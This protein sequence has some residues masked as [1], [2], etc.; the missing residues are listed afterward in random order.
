MPSRSA[1]RSPTPVALLLA[2]LAAPAVAEEL[3]LPSDPLAGTVIEST[4]PSPIGSSAVGANAAPMGAESVMFS[5]APS[6]VNSSGAYYNPTLGSH[7]RARYNTQSYGQQAGTLELGT[8]KLAPFDNGMAFIDGQVQMNDESHVGYNIGVGYRWLTLPLFP[9]SPDDQK[10][11]GVSLWSDGT[12]VGGD[13]FF[14]QVGVSLEFL[15]DHLDFRANGYA[16]V[17]DRHQVRDLAA[18]GEL[19]FSGNGLAQQLI[20]V[21]DTALTVGELELAGRIADLD[22]WVFGGAYGFN[23][24]GYEGAGGKVGL[25]GYAT[26][27]LLLSVAIANDDEF[28]TN[29]LF[30]ATWF[31]GRTRAE[32]CPRGVLTD[33]FREPVV[34]NNYVATQQSVAVATAD[35][36]VDPDNELIRIVHVDSTAAAGGDGTFESPLNSLDEVFAN[37]QENDIVL[38]HGGSVFTGQGATLQDGQTF[39]GEGNNNSFSVNTFAFGTVDL[40]ETAAGAQA[41]AIPTINA[42][43]VAGVTLADNNTVQNLAFDGGVSAIVTD[44]TLG[45]HNMTLQDLTIANTTSDGIALAA[46]VAADLG[47]IDGDD[48]TTDTFNHLGAVAITDIEFSGVG[49]SD[50]S[51]DA[52]SGSPDTTVAES[53]AISNIESSGA[54]AQSI[55]IRNTSDLT[56]AS[57]SIT[58]FDY[59]GGTVGGGAL[60]I[61][62]TGSSTVVTQSTFSGGTGANPTIAVTANEGT[63]TIGSTNSITDVPGTAVSVNGNMAAVNIGAEISTDETATT[64]VSGGGVLVNAN[65]A[66]VSFTGAIDTHNFD[67]VTITDAQAGVTFG[68]EEITSTGT[69]DTI[70]INGA[71]TNTTDPAQITFNGDISN[72]ADGRVVNIDGGD[73]AIAFNGTVTEEGDGVLIQNRADDTGASIAFNEQVAITTTGANHGVQLSG[74]GETSAVAFSNVQIATENG[75]GILGDGGVLNIEDNATTPVNTITTANGRAIDLTGGSSA[76]GLT[77]AEVNVNA[78]GMGAGVDSAILLSDFQGDVTVNGGTLNTTG[79]AVG[80]LNAGVALTD[81]TIS[82]TGNQAV[83]ASINNDTNRSV[84]LTNVQANAG[85]LEFDTQ[86][87]STGALSVTVDNS[88]ATNS[89]TVGPVSFDTAG[90]GASSLTMDTVDLNGNTLDF[91]TADSSSLTLNLNSV[92]GDALSFLSNSSA[93]STVVINDSTVNGMAYTS[94]GDG[95]ID[96][97]ATD[98]SGTGNVTFST[99]GSGGSSATLTNVDMGTGNFAYTTAGSSTLAVNMDNVDGAAV[100]FGSGSSGNSTIDIDDSTFTANADFDVTG[101]GNLAATMDT[102]TA[103]GNTT[104][105]VT[106]SGDGSLTMTSVNTGGTLTAT[107][108]GGSTGDLT[109]NATDSGNTT[110]FTGVTVNQQGTGAASGSFTNVT[111]TSGIDFDSASDSSSTLVVNGG[112]YNNNDIEFDETGSGSAVVTVSNVTTDLGAITVNEGGAG[113]LDVNLTSVGTAANQAGAVT[114]TETGAGDASLIMSG[115]DFDGAIALDESGDGS[116]SATVNNVTSTGGLTV[117]EAGVGNSTVNADGST[118]GGD[119]VVSEL[120]AGTAN[121]SLTNVTTTGGVDFDMAGAGAGSLIV[122]GGSYDGLISANV[123]NGTTGNFIGRV[124]NGTA[125]SSVSNPAQIAFNSQNTGTVT[126]E[127]SGLDAS[128]VTGANVDAISLTTGASVSNADVTVSSNAS[129]ETNDGSVLNLTT[130]GGVVDFLLSGNSFENASASDTV[131]FNIAN[132]TLNA[133][134][135]GNSLQNSVGDALSLTNPAANSQVNLALSNN[136]P[137]GADYNFFNDN[138]VDSTFRISATDATAVDNANAGDVTFDAGDVFEFDDTLNVPQP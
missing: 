97:I 3:T 46:V 53:I 129:V 60:L 84:S 126:Y 57:T 125:I 132:T 79:Q 26:P 54:V 44:A 131:Q 1:F 24:G 89:P 111:S 65:E 124:I 106:S 38:A 92:E 117:N 2:A 36:L 115:G 55:V 109:L 133:T 37:S 64:P 14:P 8:M 41:G 90:T 81:V 130:A 48:D 51:I 88:A 75:T 15:G 100:S 76:N 118:L 95:G 61:D 6:S 112:D 28:D 47:D 63:V 105:D 42:S 13:S 120:A 137:A 87:G 33:R 11:M 30:S 136:G 70:T 27:D 56:G 5:G 12:S 19:S 83:S 114:V 91:T 135:T 99:S 66:T 127:V 62:S 16:P 10:I 138:A 18:T 17:G 31:I 59:M 43:P 22:A 98:V 86:A 82:S 108:G 134:I 67:S 123:A 7:I 32:N 45:S 122:D 128:F 74:N 23:G 34:R 73:D 25:R 71:G 20:G 49:G 103:V 107:G 94:T 85:A 72:D 52:E 9:F 110:A 50:I 21:R 29:A 80:A 39:I 35:Q 58:N 69:G 77:F 102:V 96:A 113:S 78:D 93:D 121:T 116:A 68:T 119:I 4:T 104:L 40:P 101:T